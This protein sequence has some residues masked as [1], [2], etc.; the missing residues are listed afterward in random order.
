MMNLTKKKH[1]INFTQMHLNWNNPK[2]ELTISNF[3]LTNRQFTL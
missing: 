3:K 1:T 2:K